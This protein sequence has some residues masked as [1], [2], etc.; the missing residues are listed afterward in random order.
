MRTLSVKFDPRSK[1]VTVLFASLLL[2]FRFSLIIELAFM[3]LLFLLFILE[4]SWQRGLFYY[5]SCLSIL[6]LSDWLLNYI[7][8]PFI[9]FISFG[10]I[11]LRRFFP[12]IMAAGF[13]A[14]KTKTSQWIATLKK[15]HFPFSIIVPLA[16][17]FRFFPTFSQDIKHLVNAMRFRGIIHSFWD[18]IRHPFRTI[19]YLV[20]PLLMSTENISLDLSAASLTRGLGN[21]EK[22]TSIYA[23]RFAWYD[24]FL[25]FIIILLGIGG[26]IL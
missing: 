1:L 7:N 18:L 24:Y 19:E 5:L 10:V 3:T 11:V 25:C 4:G 15:W 23:I 17:L 22:Q 2:M 14:N 13:A 12:T 9:T 20:V 21:P 16:V 26:F 6:W 8:H